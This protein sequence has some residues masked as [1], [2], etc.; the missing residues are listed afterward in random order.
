MPT[1]EIL[2]PFQVL[3][4]QFDQLIAT[5]FDRPAALSPVVEI[6]NAINEASHELNE[7]ALMTFGYYFLNLTERR[8][9]PEVWQVYKGNR[10]V[11]SETR[12]W[13]EALGFALEHMQETVGDEELLAFYRGAK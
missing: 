5:T 10:K 12:H 3:L 2:Q 1:P 11:G 6:D 9:D 7:K 8:C 13:N 4:N